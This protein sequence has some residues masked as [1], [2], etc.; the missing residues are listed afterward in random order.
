MN[1]KSI[2]ELGNRPLYGRFN[3]M[4]LKAHQRNERGLILWVFAGLLVML[5]SIPASQFS[6]EIDTNSIVDTFLSIKPYQTSSLLG[7]ASLISGVVI[8]VLAC[9][10]YVRARRNIEEGIYR[11]PDFFHLAFLGVILFACLFVGLFL[12]EM[13]GA[14]WVARGD[15]QARPQFFGAAYQ[16]AALAVINPIAAA[17]PLV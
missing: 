4:Q 5:C 2:S 14:H 1:A 11:G 7:L 12:M 15:S 17:K 8:G 10:R 13:R 6:R 9:F 16:P 3:H